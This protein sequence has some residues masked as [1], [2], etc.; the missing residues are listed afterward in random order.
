MNGGGAYL[1]VL[2]HPNISNYWTLNRDIHKQGVYRKG[3]GDLHSFPGCLKPYGNH[4]F[5]CPRGGGA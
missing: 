3:G 4:G 1:M 5:N 2:F